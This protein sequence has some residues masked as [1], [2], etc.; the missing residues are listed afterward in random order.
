M[1]EILL[2]D[3]DAL[4]RGLLAE[5]L[6]E[7]GYRVHHANNGSNALEMLLERQFGLLITDMDMPFGGG[8]DII[9]IVRHRHP[10]LRV[11]AVS[12]GERGGGQNWSVSALDHGAAKALAKPLER[13]TLLAAVEEVAPRGE[14][15]TKR[16]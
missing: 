3:D 8:L 16:A 7:A 15:R 10:G 1:T 12:G 14:S 5:W 13:R 6:V 2:V 9:K 4:V 11:I